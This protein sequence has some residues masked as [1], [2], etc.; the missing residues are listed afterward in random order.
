MAEI[1]LSPVDTTGA[2][3]PQVNQLT[4]LVLPLLQRLWHQEPPAILY[5]YTTRHGLQ[6]ILSERAI[7]ASDARY[8]ND[9]QE[10]ATAIDLVREIL[11][12][13][14]P[15]ASPK[16]IKLYHQIGRMLELMKVNQD[17]FL[18]SM[19]ADGGDDLTQWRA[20]SKPGNGYCIG[21]DAP[22]I[23]RLL[24]E[25][26]VSSHFAPCEY[27]KDRQ[28]DLMKEIVDGAEQEL[29]RT[30]IGDG[31]SEK[32]VVTRALSAFGVAF[33]V[34]APIVKHG[35]FSAEH[36]WRLILAAFSKSD[37]RVRF[38]DAGRLLVPFWT[39]SLTKEGS[40]PPIKEV[41]IGPTPHTRLE[42]MAV[43]ALLTVAGLPDVTIRCSS[44]PYRDW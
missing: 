14:E 40:P 8:L 42:E 17:T 31:E 37:P 16:M 7:I 24:A 34:A 36:E 27:N 1:N 10:L 4:P 6:G 39:V 25:A 20:Y 44:I 15:N 12:A 18:F 22:A 23:A 11:R 9:A 32:A 33:L 3:K 30:D 43:K 2:G 38:R 19:S 35:A 21:F 13:R 29:N 26:G 41:V 5:H 28:F